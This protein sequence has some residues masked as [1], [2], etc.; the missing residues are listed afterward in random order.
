M[1]FGFFLGICAA[2][3]WSIVNLIDKYMVERFSKE[4]GVGALIV[5]SSLFPATL[6]PIA[7]LIEK[8]VVSL[9]FFEILILLLAGSLTVVWISLYLLAL[10]DDDASTVMPLFQLTPIAALVTAY[11]IL[12]ELPNA[13]E[14]LAGGVILIGSLILGF[15]FASGKFKMKLLLYIGGASIAI[16]LMNTLFKFVAEDTSFWTS[17]FWYALGITITGIGLFTLHTSYRDQF[18]SFVK[19]NAGIGLFLNGVN[20]SLTIFGDIIF[21]YAV[22]LT[23]IAL[24]QTTE[25]FQPIFVFIIGII[26][27]IFIPKI[28][29]EDFSKKILIQKLCGLFFVCLGTILIYTLK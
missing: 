12:G 18:V 29:H 24:I 20:E 3:L 16:A 11:L 28:V 26:L 23:P 21:A 17:I 15:E 7:F 14:L 8:G 2:F 22:V 19:T 6:L 13:K 10:E 5:L 1:T 25:A 9:P 4:T 27:T